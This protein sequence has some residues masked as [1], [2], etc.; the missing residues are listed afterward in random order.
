[1]GELV[2]QGPNVMMGYAESP[3]DL[4]LGRTVDRLHTGDLARLRSDGLYEIVGRRS[5]VAKVFGLRIDL[6]RVE[7]VLAG[8]GLIAVAA[9]GGDRVVLGVCTGARPV[10]PAEVA[11]IVRE[12]IGLPGTGHVLVELPE[13][14]RLPSGKTDYRTLA[15][16]AEARRTAEVPAPT[17]TPGTDELVALYAELLARPDA[18]P[19]DSFV[20][21]GGDSLSYVEMSLRLERRLGSLPP[22][23]HTTPLA[24][25]VAKPVRRRRGTM[26][27]SNVLLRAFAIV[28]IVGTHANLFT[29]LGG[30]HL[31]LGIVGFNFAR[32]QVTSAPA[33]ERLLGMLRSVARIAVPS[34]L[35]I[36]TVSLFV[37]GLGWRQILLVNG[38]TS[39]TWTEP[40][41]HYWFIEALVHIL[42]LMALLLAIPGVARLERRWSFGF[43]FALAVAGLLTRYGVVG[44]G[45]TDEIHR[46]HVIF[47]L[48]AVGWA[49]A[50]ATSQRHRVLLTLLVVASVPGFFQ[51]FERNA[52]VV[53]GMMILVWLPLV[54]VPHVVAWVAGVLA[55]ASLWIYLVHWQ[56]YPHLEH[57]IPWLATVLA[58][59]AGVLAWQLWSAAARLPRAVARSSGMK[60]GPPLVADSGGL[61]TTK[62]A[63][64]APS[65]DDQPAHVP[66]GPTRHR[67]RRRHERLRDR[68]RQT[69]GRPWHRRRHLHP[70]DLVR[71]PADRGGFRSGPRQEHPRRP[72]RGPH[73]G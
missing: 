15:E 10:D 13:I 58:L 52:Y 27:E 51:G 31:L 3:R 26:L 35:V 14:P 38:L 56:V 67:R 68:A 36:A 11:T 62:G 22:G 7:R 21:L 55:G 43:P 59:A 34:A 20:S 64:C 28:S 42:L 32:F 71:P 53:V 69:P 24:E 37:D 47:W 29:M 72:V 54:R 8:R 4:A 73:Q 57:R 70:G 66:A 45:G 44:L 5:R 61:R 6:D 63:R 33:A 48:F 41:W 30:A 65:G 1:M 16:L 12:E 49:A 19:T 40:G 9:D 2:Y 17:G 50:K 23:W 60:C 25:L 46:A 18:Q 39:R